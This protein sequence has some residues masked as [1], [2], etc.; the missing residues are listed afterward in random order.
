MKPAKVLGVD[1]EGVLFKAVGRPLPRALESV[2]KLAQSGSFEKVY[3]VS[4]VNI[5]GRIIF[6]LRL[7]MLGFW[8]YTGI[9]RSNLYF[10]RRDRDKS[11][12]CEQLGI[13]DFIDDRLKVLH[14][15]ETVD[16]RYAFNP[17]RK[18]EFKKYPET[19]EDVT[20]TGSWDELL[21][22]LLEAEA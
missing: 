14:F 11:A 5:F 17:R 6:P 13:T 9:P 10:C 18:R 22:L 1:C 21:P 7:R 20:I 12:I 19:A 8:K 4:R 15:L 16:R 2:R 3:I